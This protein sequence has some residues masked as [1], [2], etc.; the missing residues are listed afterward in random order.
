M[1][2]ETSSSG[3]NPLST[4]KQIVIILSH[5]KEEP[6]PIFDNFGFSGIVPIID[7]VNACPGFKKIIVAKPQFFLPKQVANFFYN[8][9]KASRL[10]N[11]SVHL[12]TP[13]GGGPVN[14][15]SL[16][17]HTFDLE[18][19]G[20]IVNLD[21]I[22]PEDRQKVFR[23]ITGNLEFTPKAFSRQCLK[24]EYRILCDYVQKVFLSHQG[25]FDSVTPQKLQVMVAVILKLDVNWAQV[26]LSCLAQVAAKQ[27]SEA[28]DGQVVKLSI[29]KPPLCMSSKVSLPLIKHFSDC[30][31]TSTEKFDETLTVSMTKNHIEKAL[32]ISRNL[33]WTAPEVYRPFLLSIG[34]SYS[35]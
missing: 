14:V 16:I 8:W 35:T 26:P 31:W 7:M 17:L 24:P 27:V 25:T 28:V 12:S 18:D 29:S 2:E 3:Q 13:S 4:D 10:E 30:R 15:H 33:Y 11:I 9:R 1:V 21:E 23:Q 6:Y 32:G 34:Q 5:V 19:K 22:T 20:L